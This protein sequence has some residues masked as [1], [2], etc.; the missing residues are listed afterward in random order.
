[1]GCVPHGIR[2]PCQFNNSLTKS[3]LYTVLSD[4]MHAKL[5]ECPAGGLMH[6]STKPLQGIFDQIY[7]QPIQSKFGR[8]EK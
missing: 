6:V 1:M 8:Y 4:T 3:F 7:N 5:G 2:N